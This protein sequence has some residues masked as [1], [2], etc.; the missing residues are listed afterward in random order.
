MIAM[1]VLKDMN[2]PLTKRIRLILGTNEETGSKCL[3]HYVEKEGHIDMGFTPDG[4]FPGVHGEK[5]ALGLDFESVR[6]QIK[7]IRG[8]VASNVVCNHCTMIVDRKKRC[9]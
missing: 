8:G 5:G 6:T 9:G 7:E 2:V 3:A 1:K 4:T